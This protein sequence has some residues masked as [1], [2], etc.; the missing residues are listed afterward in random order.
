MQVHHLSII[1]NSGGAW[2]PIGLTSLVFMHSVL[3]DSDL[4]KDF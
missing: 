1:D 4:D 2:I 3:L